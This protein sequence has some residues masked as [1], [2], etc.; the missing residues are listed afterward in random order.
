[1]PAPLKWT[2][3]KVAVLREQV[4]GLRA[5]RTPWKIIV[6]LLGYEKSWLWGL[7]K[8]VRGHS[9][10]KVGASSTNPLQLPKENNDT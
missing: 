9:T 5:K 10:G 1:M 6:R 8:D 2:P 7:T 3:E 4:L